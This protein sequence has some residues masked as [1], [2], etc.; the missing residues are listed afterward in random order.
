MEKADGDRKA[1]PQQFHSRSTFHFFVKSSPIIERESIHMNAK[2]KPFKV[3]L[4]I[5]VT[6]FEFLIWGPIWGIE[7]PFSP[8]FRDGEC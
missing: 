7:N 6:K 5:H 2:R 8:N 4:R 1:P 3:K